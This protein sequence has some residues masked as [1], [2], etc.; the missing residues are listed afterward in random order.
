MS[1]GALT[2]Q[3][4]DPSQLKS[5]HVDLHINLK[6]SE[7]QYRLRAGEFLI[8]KTKEIIVTNDKIAAFMEGKSSLAKQGISVE[9]SSTFIEPESD[10]HM[11]LE[12]FNA[13]QNTVVINDGQPIAKMYITKIIDHYN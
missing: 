6:S 1:S 4:F 2:I 12:I 9:Q 7:R 13:S 10:N 5:A 11:T 8:A 3:P